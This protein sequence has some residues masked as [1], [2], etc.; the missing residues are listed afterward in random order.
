MADGMET[1]NLRMQSFRAI[2]NLI[3]LYQ[4]IHQLFC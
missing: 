2:D 3:S 1:F 4:Y